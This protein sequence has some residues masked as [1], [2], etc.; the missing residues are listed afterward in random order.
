MT[1][2]CGNTQKWLT[3]SV[4]SLQSLVKLPSLAEPQPV[5]KPVAAL[6]HQLGLDAGIVSCQNEIPGN[7]LSLSLTCA[8]TEIISINADTHLS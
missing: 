6:E 5:L 4:A 7:L 1:V 3:V 8:E 2:Q